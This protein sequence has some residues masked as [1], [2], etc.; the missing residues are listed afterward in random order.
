[1][2]FEFV[3]GGEL[4]KRL[5]HEGR[6]SQDVAL[7]YGSQIL[8][9]LYYLHRAGVIYWD[10][11][12]ENLLIDKNGN[13]KLADFGFAKWLGHKEKTYT[14]C[15]TPEYLAP[16]LIHSD[17]EGYT[18]AVDWWAL[19]VLMYEM[20]VG[21]PPFYDKDPIGIYEKIFRLT[22]EFPEFLSMN[23]KDLIVRLL[24]PKYKKRLGCVDNGLEIFWHE[25]F[26]GVPFDELEQGNI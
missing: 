15:G 4:F 9:T 3:Q 1:M 7:F 18:R 2:V 23:A 13:I 14:L 6:F 24:N 26:N 20:M 8:L 25:F 19:G 17:K 5:R 12:P 10:L 11:K 22:I 16:E 21:F